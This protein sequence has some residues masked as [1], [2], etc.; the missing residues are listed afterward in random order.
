M[1]ELKYKRTKCPACSEIALWPIFYSYDTPAMSY[2]QC[3]LT[4]DD[5]I[6]G[7]IS[8]SPGKP[9]YLKECIK[10][11]YI[12]QFNAVTVEKIGKL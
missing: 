3:N 2:Q 9:V 7:T 8:L 1:P 4:R 11:G 6:H 5:I 12:A 10:C